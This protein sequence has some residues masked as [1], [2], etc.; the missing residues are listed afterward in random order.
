MINKANLKK[1]LMFVAVA[2]PVAFL[3]VS[4][5]FDLLGFT[6]RL[7]GLNNSNMPALILR[8]LDLSNGTPPIIYPGQILIIALVMLGAYEYTKMLSAVN[9]HNAFWLGYLWIIFMSVAY[10]FNRQIPATL[11]NSVLLMLV[12][13]EAFFFGKGAQHGRWKR[14]SLFFSG[15]I[16]LNIASISLL[17]LYREPFAAM[18]NA[19]SIW[20]FGKLEVVVVVTATF[21]CDSAAYFAGS[22][23]GKRK[24]STS[25][26]PNKTVEGSLAGLLTSVLFMSI[27]WI[28]IRAPELPIFIGIILGIIIGVMAQVGDLLVSL[29]KRYF[30]VKDASDM[31]PGHGGI[32]DRFDSLFFTAP[33]LYLFAWLLSRWFEL[34]RV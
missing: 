28:F 7:F 3:I 21:F 13:F 2:V 11:S 4:S 1:R 20:V 30:R 17:S 12:A 19:P 10:L 31:I 22:A 15:I 32:L 6:L 9:K 25:I 5:Q 18:F 27:C 24:L 16:F 26:S 29:I 34:S 33:A 23:W 14:A 8:L